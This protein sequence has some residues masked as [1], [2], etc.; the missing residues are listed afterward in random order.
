MLLNQKAIVLKKLVKFKEVVSYIPD[1]TVKFTHAYQ[2]E[3]S[4]RGTQPITVK[5]SLI[6]FMIALSMLVNQA[7]I[8]DQFY[9]RFTQN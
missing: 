7:I 3:N 4:H 1:S 5:R 2:H 8:P 6:L 9:C